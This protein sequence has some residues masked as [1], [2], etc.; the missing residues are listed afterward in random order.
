MRENPSLFQRP[1][2]S[3]PLLKSRVLG[4]CNPSGLTSPL[5]GLCPLCCLECS[6]LVTSCWLDR[7]VWPS[8]KP[9]SPALFQAHLFAGALTSLRPVDSPDSQHALA[10]SL[11]QFALP[12]LRS[13]RCR[14]LTAPR[15]PRA[16]GSRPQLQPFFQQRRF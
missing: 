1:G 3:L 6:R 13:P 5:S 7:R 9:D 15:R 10:G 2:V 12:L 14:S 8:A 4:C 11:S 16:T